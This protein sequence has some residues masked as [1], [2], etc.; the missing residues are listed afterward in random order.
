MEEIGCA[1]KNVCELGEIEEYRNQWALRQVSYCFLAD[2]DGGKGMPDFEEDEIADGF[3][4]I[5]MSIEN[6]IKT[7]E[8]EVPVEDYEGKFIQLRD[9]TLLKEALAKR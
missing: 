3:E 7:L 2:L 1:V 8:G 6:A 4:P 5:W 9:L